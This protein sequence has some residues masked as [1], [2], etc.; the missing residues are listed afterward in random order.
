VQ[1]QERV[2]LRD[3]NTQ[4]APELR[5][6]MLKVQVRASIA[7]NYLSHVSS[8]CPSGLKEAIVLGADP[9]APLPLLL[10]LL[11]LLLPS[12]LRFECAGGPQ[13]CERA[14]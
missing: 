6:Q 8:M 7:Q 14:A 2:A 10:L 11:L 4:I 3:Q 13:Q 12:V 1:Q 5:E 9:L